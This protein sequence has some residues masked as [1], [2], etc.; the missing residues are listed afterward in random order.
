VGVHFGKTVVK[1]TAKDH[2][3]LGRKQ[4]R[5]KDIQQYV[6]FDQCRKDISMS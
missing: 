4:R 5:G 6:F 1:A 2:A 3:L